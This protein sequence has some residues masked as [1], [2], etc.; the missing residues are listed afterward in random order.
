MEEG[1]AVGGQAMGLQLTGR[2]A[3]PAQAGGLLPKLK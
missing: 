1:E 2:P 3:H